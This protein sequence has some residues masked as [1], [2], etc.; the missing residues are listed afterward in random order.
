MRLINLDRA[1][2]LAADLDLLDTAIADIREMAVD[3]IRLQGAGGAPVFE[4]DRVRLLAFL[5]AERTETVRKLHELG[6]EL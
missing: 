1:S 6:V 4:V 3:E 5:Y 2:S